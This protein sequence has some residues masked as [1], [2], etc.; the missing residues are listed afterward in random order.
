MTADSQPKFSLGQL[1]ATPGALEA[2]QRAGQSA[3]EFLQRHVRGDWGEVCKEDRQANEQALIDGTR[4]LS[5]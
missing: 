1:L 2:L 5:A 4:I 3:T